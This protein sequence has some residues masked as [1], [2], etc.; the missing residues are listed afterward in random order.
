MADVIK[1]RPAEDPDE[2]LTAALGHYDQLFIVGWDKRG[3]LDMRATLGLDAPECVYLIEL[4]KHAIMS[5][6]TE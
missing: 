6:A 4:F 3:Q 2:V 1:L 5:E